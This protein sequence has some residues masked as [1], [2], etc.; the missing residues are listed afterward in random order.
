MT[1]VLGLVAVHLALNFPAST[2]HI[3]SHLL[4]DW[5]TL[6]PQI[7]NKEAKSG[8]SY[9]FT[10]VVFFPFLTLLRSLYIVYGAISASL[11]AT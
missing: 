7:G 5:G 6:Y 4:T 10:V 1:N 3:E 9:F 8:R 2:P 11:Q